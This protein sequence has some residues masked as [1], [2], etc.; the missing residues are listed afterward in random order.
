M[1]EQ[2]KTNS[3]IQDK[4]NDKSNAFPE[5][6]N[7]FRESFEKQK[8]HFP[9]VRS[10]SAETRILKLKKLR[11]AI[12]TR[13]AEIKEALYKDFRKPAAEVDIT[14][15]FTTL[16]ELD[17]AVKNLKRWMKPA[18]TATPIALLGA[19]SEIRYEP[20]GVVLIIG[21]WN[22]PF[23]LMITP[24]ISAISAGNCVIAK[25]SEV[26]PHTSRLVKSL[27]AQVFDEAEVACFEGDAT[28]SQNLLKLPFDH[29][30]FT[31]STRL[32][33]IVM[34][35][36]ARHLS[37]VTLE[38]GGKSPVIVEKS[39][40]LAQAAKRIMWGKFLNGGQTCV[41]PDY[42]YIHEDQLSEFIAES[43]KAIQTSFGK[44]ESEREKSKDLTRII[45]SA[46]Y[47]RIKK[48]T[49]DTLHQGAQAETGGVFNDLENYVSPT[50][51]TK[52]TSQS[53]I[54]SEEIFGPV[55]PIL[56]YSHLNE[57]YSALQSADKPLALY[58]FSQNQ[59][60]IEEILKNTTA[61]GTCINHTIIH[62]INPHLPFGGSGA[63]GIGNYHGYFGFKTF[64]HERSILRQGSLAALDFLAPPYRERVKRLIALTLRFFT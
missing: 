27:V 16:A 11:N 54:M 28:V 51:L 13:S 4:S 48:L 44:T 9:S 61:G 46:H 38:L 40:N 42:L 23:H 6:Q 43:K 32:G 8:H 57:V 30:F 14:E 10:T 17:F 60:K 5:H 1:I 29:I 19:R 2:I 35:A 3:T 21:P 37:S 50:L 41:A 26:A 52:I 62:L 49:Q 33:K 39:A 63:S 64:S 45:N 58:I 24:L 22:Y 59:T 7:K 31:G 36:A 47:Q 20:K 25:P 15:I 55:L 34:E 56:T 18:K 53:P 12:T